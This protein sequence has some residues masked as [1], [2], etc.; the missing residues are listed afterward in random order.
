MQRRDRKSD[1]HGGVLIA[2]R[3]DLQLG[4]ISQSD[5]TELISGNVSLSNQKMTVAAYYRQPN[6]VDEEYISN[7]MEEIS[8]LKSRRKRNVL[9]IGGDFN[10]PDI[11]RV[12]LTITGNQNPNRVNQS[13]LDIIADNGLEQ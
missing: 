7:T 3:R 8:K 4:N 6:R 12:D 2:A 5:S 11:N 13:F 9:V 1:K 10:L